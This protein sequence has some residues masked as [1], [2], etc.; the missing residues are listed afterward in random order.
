[1]LGKYMISDKPM[2]E[3]EWA[4]ERATVIDAEP[5]MLKQRNSSHIQR[6]KPNAKE[7]HLHASPDG[8]SGPAPIR[9]LNVASG[10]KGKND[11]LHRQRG[12]KLGGV[13]WMGWICKFRVSTSSTR[14]TWMETPSGAIVQNS[15]SGTASSFGVS[16]PMRARYPK[17]SG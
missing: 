1:V 6:R 16:R 11:R 8:P 17:P 7:S 10:S 13:V 5:A 2:T 3:E 14:E 15:D 4:R 12:Q 9:T